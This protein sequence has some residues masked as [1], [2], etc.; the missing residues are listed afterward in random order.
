MA[1]PLTT[2]TAVKP[3]AVNLLCFII[4]SDPTNPG[5]RLAV[6]FR[7][8]LRTVKAL[9]AFPAASRAASLADVQPPYAMPARVTRV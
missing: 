7:I 5:F 3:T 2:N 4:L 9:R 6:T 1:Q 8:I